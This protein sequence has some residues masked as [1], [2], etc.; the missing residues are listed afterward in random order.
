MKIWG[1]TCW[2]RRG[3]Y[4][5]KWV[6]EEA[7]HDTVRPRSWLVVVTKYVNPV[8][9]HGL[10]LAG[11]AVRCMHRV[12]QATWEQR[13]EAMC[14]HFIPLSYKC[15]FLRKM[16]RLFQGNM[17]V[18]KYYK[19]SQNCRICCEINECTK[20][21]ENRFL[22]GL[23]PEIQNILVDLSYSSISQLFE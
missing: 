7:V 1:F 4:L 14:D 16:Q 11:R 5:A 15:D 6:V 17:S 12:Q 8:V 9:P 10:G 13:K 23:Q 22:D 20:A 2:G 3:S 19:E 21:I 18:Q